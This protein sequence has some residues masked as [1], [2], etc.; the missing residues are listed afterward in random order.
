MKSLIVLYFT[1]EGVA[2]ELDIGEV[3]PSKRDKLQ[4]CG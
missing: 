1:Y 3:S 4:G 2:Y